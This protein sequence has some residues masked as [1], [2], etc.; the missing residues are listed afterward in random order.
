ME[1][2]CVC[3]SQPALRAS[4]VF[5]KNRAKIRTK[6]ESGTQNNFGGS[7]NTQHKRVMKFPSSMFPAMM[8]PKWLENVPETR[9]IRKV[10]LVQGEQQCLDDTTDKATS[11]NRLLTLPVHTLTFEIPPLINET[12]SS[13]SS[14]VMNHSEVLLWV[15]PLLEGKYQ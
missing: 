12:S 6:V 9:L 14:F 11:S 10:T 3:T 2:S 1:A 15:K 13:E 5:E 7:R 8:L 4:F